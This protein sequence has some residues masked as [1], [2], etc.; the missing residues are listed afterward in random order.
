MRPVCARL[1]AT[2]LTRLACTRLLAAAMTATPVYAIAQNA[3]DKAYGAQAMQAA[4]EALRK[5]MGGQT[6]TMIFAD[7]LEYQSNEGEPAF[8]WEGQAWF[9]G[10]IDKVWVKMKGEYLPGPNEFEEAEVQALYSRATSSYFDVQLG[11]RYDAEPERHFAV[12]GVQGLAPYGLEIDATAFVSEDGDVSTRL[13]A[14]YELF[15][16]Q[17]LILQPRTELD[18]AARDVPELGVGSGL[19]TVEV[20]LRLRY[21]F[22]REVAP[23]I[24]VSYRRIFGETADFARAAGHDVETTS[25]VAGLRFWF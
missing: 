22:R 8:L 4:R 16:T 2:A 3:A 24:G 7:R 19:S 10:D 14:E 21:E 17:K 13:E 23:H 1:P 25:F 20:G 5:G 15:L 11:Y 12:F 18:F 9:G 6:T